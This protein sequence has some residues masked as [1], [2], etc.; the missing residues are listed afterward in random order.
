[1]SLLILLLFPK[2]LRGQIFLADGDVSFAR[3]PFAAL[4]VHGFVVGLP[5]A[6]SVDVPVEHAEGGCDKN[7]VVD[8]D[9][10]GSEAAGVSDVFCGD[11]FAALLDLAGDDHQGFELVGDGGV[12][13]VSLD[14]LDQIL[15][16][17][18][19]GCGDSSVD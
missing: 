17:V 11:V 15:V 2:L 4:A 3:D 8:L 12:L 13:E 5:G 14:A 7:R 9:V 10:R 6:E 1:M 18:E 16:V 19:A